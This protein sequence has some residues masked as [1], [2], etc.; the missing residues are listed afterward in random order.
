M[1]SGQ[2]W[3]ALDDTL[4]PQDWTEFRQVAHRAVDDVVEYLA[5][6]R[7]HPVWSRI[8][9][10]SFLRNDRDPAPLGSRPVADVYADF[11]RHILPYRYGNIHP[12]FWGWVNGSGAPAAVLADFLASAMNP[13][14]AGGEHAATLL[15][16]RVL[17]WLRQLF[18]F[19]ETSGGL[20][21]SGASMANL[22][23][24][25]VARTAKAPVDV[26]RRG[27]RAVDRPMVVFC[28]TE[29]HGS[30]ERAVEL[31]G[32]GRDCL[33]RVPVDD[34]FRIDI[35]ALRVAIAESMRN[36]DQPFC[37]VGNAGTVNTGAVDDLPGLAAVCRES[38]LWF[39]VDGAF[40]ALSRV[41]RDYATGVDG[42]EL[43]DSI[44][45]DLHKWPYLPAE[46]GCILVRRRADQLATFAQESPYLGAG[47]SHLTDQFGVFSSAGLQLT[48]GFRALKVWMAVETYGLDRLGTMIAQNITQARYLADRVAESRRLEL[49]APVALNIVCFR[50]N[51]GDGALPDL[52]ALNRRILGRLHDEGL[53]V[54][55]ATT[56]RGSLVLR[57]ALT[58]HRTRRSDL[59]F[60]VDTV[61]RLGGEL[62]RGGRAQ[63]PSVAGPVTE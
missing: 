54:P 63:E 41:S 40:G 7:E 34:A 16:L 1:T 2:A 8:P 14:G 61:E 4:D 45:F 23:G 27:L 42:I 13:N 31:L 20:F 44:A 35:T 46:V 30:V 58:N 33:R 12:R 60:L 18:A 21:V 52:D 55:S 51:D 3:P 15:E 6:L 59:D 43:A 56:I 17:S 10:G 62:V 36:G 49:M 19:P 48:R 57:V 47:Y 29:T 37:V 22:T 32:L 53:A 50:Y 25:A 38:D 26:R 28:S 39:H 5:T 11:R 24:L 9:D